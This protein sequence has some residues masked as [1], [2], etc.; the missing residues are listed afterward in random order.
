MHLRELQAIKIWKIKI[1]ISFK[2]WLALSNIC[3]D[4]CTAKTLFKV[5]CLS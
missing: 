2:D 1:R 3:D 4:E 5:S